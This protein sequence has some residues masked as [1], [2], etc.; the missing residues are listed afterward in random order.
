MKSLTVKS[1]ILTSTLAIFLLAYVPIRGQ[2]QEKVNGPVIRATADGLS[3][4]P[5]DRALL[6]VQIQT[7]A[8]TAQAAAEKNAQEY[9]QAVATLR[10]R[11][12][13]DVDIQT[14]RYRYITRGGSGGKS[15]IIYRDFCITLNTIDPPA[16]GRAV[17]ATIDA[18]LTATVQFT[19]S[20][21]Q[22]VKN[23]AAHQA[24]IKAREKADAL[25]SS[26]GMKVLRVVAVEDGPTVV[27]LPLEYGLA[28]P[29]TNPRLTIRATVTVVVEIG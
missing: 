26:L 8:E 21:E 4:A 23:Q 18:N 10:K 16:V 19:C 20:T 15:S 22:Q 13:Q 11:L 14:I 5:T 28:G 25:A 29:S 7:E 1:R 12:G 27:V 3:S 24:A 6:F 2:S 17:D 9:G